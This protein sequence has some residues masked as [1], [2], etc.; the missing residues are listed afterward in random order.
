MTRQVKL[1][2]E[3]SEHI[4][5]M[6]QMKEHPLYVTYNVK[7][8]GFKPKTNAFNEVFIESYYTTKSQSD[9]KN[10]DIFE[11]MLNSF[12]GYSQPAY[13]TCGKVTFEV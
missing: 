6:D 10:V 12:E 4:K 13:V 11:N 2:L 5:A 1:L 9:Q 3:Q 7:P 8:C